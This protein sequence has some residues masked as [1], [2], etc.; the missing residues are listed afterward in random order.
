[1]VAVL[2]SLVVLTPGQ[3]PPGQLVTPPVSST[4]PRRVHDIGVAMRGLLRAQARA[5]TDLESYRFVQQMCSLFR[6]VVRHP[7]WE[8]SDRLMAY[9][10]QLSAR[11]RKVSQRLQTQLSRRQREAFHRAYEPDTLAA[12]DRFAK[13]LQWMG[14]TLGGPA[15]LV[16]FAQGLSG[17]STVSASLALG[18]AGGAAVNDAQQLIELIQRTIMPEF[19]DRNGGPGTMVYYAP[20]HALVVRATRGVHQRLGGLLQG[21]R[22]DGR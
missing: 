10:A 12:T 21:A 11:L 5:R 9:K 20:V 19:W 14:A 15:Q 3:Q 22:R 8:S 1:M 6:E 16:T 7:R 13:E 2:L 18:G 4:V 17:A